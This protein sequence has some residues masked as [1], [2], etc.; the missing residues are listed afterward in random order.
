M[1]MKK[2]YKYK[3]SNSSQSSFAKLNRAELNCVCA[4]DVHKT[5][6]KNTWNSV[7]LH[8]NIQFFRVPAIQFGAGETQWHFLMKIAWI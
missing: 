1:E 7:T 4:G 6:M 3:L 5:V 2:V 8:M